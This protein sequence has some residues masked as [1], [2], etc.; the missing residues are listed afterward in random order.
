[1]SYSFA[2]LCLDAVFCGTRRIRRIFLRHSP[3]SPHSPHFC[4]PNLVEAGCMNNVETDPVFQRAKQAA[5]AE[6]VEGIIDQYCRDHPSEAYGLLVSRLNIL[7]V[8]K[9]KEFDRQHGIMEKEYAR[10]RCFF[11]TL[12]RQATDRTVNVRPSCVNMR[13]SCYRHTAVGAILLPSTP[14]CDRRHRSA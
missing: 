3:H 8:Q 13:P 9:W 1:M 2:R 14:S 6:E 7:L 10:K 4:C 5:T 12:A 11:V